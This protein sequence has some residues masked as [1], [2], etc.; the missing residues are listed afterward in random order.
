MALTRSAFGSV[1][2]LLAAVPLLLGVVR[3]ASA[4]AVKYNLDEDRTLVQVQA[5][6]LEGDEAVM[7]QARRLLAEE[8]PVTA[9]GILTTWISQNDRTG[10][11]YLPQAYLLRGEAWMGINDLYEALYDFETVIKQ[12][13]QTEEFVMA[14]DHELAIALRYAGGEKRRA[15]L[16]FWVDASDIAVEI[17]IRTQERMPGSQLAEKAAIE[18]AD[19]YYRERELKLAGTAYDL[20]LENFPRGPNRIKAAERRIFCDIARFKGPQY[21]SASLIDASVRIKD[22][23]RVFPAEAERTGLDAALLTRLDESAAAQLLENARWYLKVSD[24][25]SARYLLKSLLKK[26]PGT[27]AADQAIAIFAERGWEQEAP[28]PADNPPAED[29][30]ETP[31][32]PAPEA[33]VPGAPGASDQPANPE[34]GQ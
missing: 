10:N 18:L 28:K 12:Y 31:A 24:E 34:G 27:I 30:A 2:A 7:A 17:F 33:T 16:I 25:P 4:Q 15:L 11:A 6:A 29:A 23:R 21:E 14:I 8:K 20:Y 9:R 13:P 22:F 26:H 32:E 19:F 3:S 1:S 5:P